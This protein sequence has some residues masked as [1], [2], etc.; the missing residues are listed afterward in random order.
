MVKVGSIGIGGISRGVH[1][2]G[3]MKSPDL[4]L[5]AV[6][7]INPEA[8]K[9][10]K[11][12]YGIDDAHCFTDYR[13]LIAC[14]DIEAI[15]ISTPNFYHYE[16]AKAAIDARKPFCL[17]KPVTMTAAQADELK[18]LAEKHG[19]KNMVCFSYRFKTSARYMRHLVRT[20]IVGDVYHVYMQYLQ[21][22]ALPVSD[23]P[24][25]WR[26]DKALAGTGALGD[27]GCHAIDLVSFVTGKKY[28]KFVAHADTYIHERRKLDGSGMGKV[29]VDDYSHFLGEMEGGTSVAFMITRMAYGRGNYQRVEVYGSR[30]GIV[31]SLDVTPGVDEIE[32]CL[33]PIG[34]ESR[35][36]TKIPVQNRFAADQMQAF[37]DI[38]AGKG[39]GLSATIEDGATVQ[40]YLQAIE[41]SAKE[42]RWINI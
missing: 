21:A 8:L 35:V 3:I 31:Y 9:R 7:D 26:Y 42:N 18:E 33:E 6:C 27:L 20:G 19:V 14:P 16:I 30:G 12:D 23:S 17:E 5:A 2:P 4:E 34:K 24:L 41:D 38:I 15:D 32:V 36:Y 39:D 10:A 22:G 37:A 40:H 28:E 29:E 1:I 25:V 11:D 13:D